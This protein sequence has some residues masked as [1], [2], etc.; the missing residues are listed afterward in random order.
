MFVRRDDTHARGGVRMMEGDLQAELPRE[1]EA[2]EGLGDHTHA[3]AYQRTTIGSYHLATYHRH[4]AE[5]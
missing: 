5:R 4:L 2:I 3:Y 1:C